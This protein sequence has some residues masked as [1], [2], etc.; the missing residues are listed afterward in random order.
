MPIITPGRRLVETNGPD[1]PCGASEVRWISEPGGLTQFGAFEEILQPGSRSSIRHWHLAEDE[2]VYVLAGEVVVVEG[3]AL[4]TLAEGDAATFPAGVEQG[5]F[6][7]NR[8][9]GPCKYLVIGTRAATEV[10]TYPDTGTKC[11]RVRA[12]PDDVWINADGTP[13][14]SPY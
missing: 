3:N 9:T 13:G 4:T 7:E 10:I 11:I 8:G 12:L 2:M 1:H 5:H 6:L 14:Q